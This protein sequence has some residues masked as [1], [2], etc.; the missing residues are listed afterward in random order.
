MKIVMKR[1]YIGAIKGQPGDVLDIEEATAKPLLES[2]MAFIAGQPV[3]VT[4]ADRNS[5]PF[6]FT[7]D[8]RV[9]AS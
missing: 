4:A 7:A 9:K 2:G 3:S 8:P 1:P 6:N 5:P